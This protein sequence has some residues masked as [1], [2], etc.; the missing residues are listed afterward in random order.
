MWRRWTLHWLERLTGKILSI[1]CCF[2]D[3]ACKLFATP[4][5]SCPADPQAMMAISDLRV[6]FAMLSICVGLLPL[7]WFAHETSAEVYR[8]LANAVIETSPSIGCNAAVC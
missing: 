6:H 4:P 1:T 3:A 2:Q 5:T 7:Q 8:S